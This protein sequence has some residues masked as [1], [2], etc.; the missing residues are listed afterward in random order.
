VIGVPVQIISKGTCLKEV[1]MMH[2]QNGDD[3]ACAKWMVM[4][5]HAQNGDG[6]ACAKL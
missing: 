6:D 3:D 5:M 4:M 2:A 1:M